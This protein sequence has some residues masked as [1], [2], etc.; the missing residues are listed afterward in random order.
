[1]MKQ[2]KKA[3]A[4]PTNIAIVGAGGIGS[5]LTNLL[6]RSLHDGGLA[7]K[8]GGTRI[9]LFDSDIVEQRNTLFQLFRHQDV[10]KK[11]VECLKGALSGFEGRLLEIIAIPHDVRSPD[12]LENQDIVLVCVDSSHGR[13]ATHSSGSEWADLRCSG[14]GFIAL[15]HRVEEA[16]LELLTAEQEPASCQLEGAI[17]SGNLQMG[18]VAAAAWGAQWA[19]Q[20][21]RAMAG[22]ENAQPPRPGSS[23]ITFGNLGFLPLKEG[24]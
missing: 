4:G 17:E 6:V 11:K 15:D 2:P 20:S 10:G 9:T 19:I 3:R 16:T 12:D 13:S 22:E 14:D 18:F 21:L 23:S 7:R 8:I 24:V 1:M 5:A